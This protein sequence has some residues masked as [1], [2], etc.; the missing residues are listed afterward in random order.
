MSAPDSEVLSFIGKLTADINA[1]ALVLSELMAAECQKTA[2]PDAHLKMLA[3]KIEEMLNMLPAG[4][5]PQA[6]QMAKWAKHRVELIL[7][8]AR[9][10]FAKG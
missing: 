5:D 2:N 10:R 6:D 7:L 4:T 8:N 9:N 3:G 1:I